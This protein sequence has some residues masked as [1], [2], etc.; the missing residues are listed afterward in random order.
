M[1]LGGALI[2]SARGQGQSFPDAN[3]DGIDDRLQ[4]PDYLAQTTTQ[5]EQQQPGLLG[6]IL[7]VTMPCPSQLPRR[8]A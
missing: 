6:R 3:Q 7:G 8:A 2:Q 5:V 4:D 1:L